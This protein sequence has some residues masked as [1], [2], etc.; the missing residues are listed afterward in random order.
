MPRL[1]LF[2][3][4]FVLYPGCR[5]L[6]MDAK[7][8]MPN[9][10]CSLVEPG[11]GEKGSQPYLAMVASLTALICTP[12]PTVPTRPLAPADYRPIHP[13][14]E[15]RMKPLP[16]RT[17]RGRG[18]GRW[19]RGR[20]GSGPRLAH[21]PPEPPPPASQQPP[22]PPSLQ[23]ADVQVRAGWPRPCPNSWGGWFGM[24]AQYRRPQ[25][26]PVAERCSLKPNLRFI[27]QCEG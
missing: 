16:A 23:A 8:A 15:G 3:A 18:R 20:W 14:L 5:R 1:Q 27:M 22:P 25:E 13:G 17:P 2:T 11:H 21:S 10:G 9:H 24:G 12:P 6:E 19:G 4:P 26:E 7:C